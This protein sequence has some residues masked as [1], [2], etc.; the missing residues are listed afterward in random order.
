METTQRF[1]I[2]ESH[3]LKHSLEVFH[4]A[5]EIYNHQVVMYPYLEKQKDIIF[6]SAILHD[7]CDKKYMDQE[8]GIAM[9]KHHMKE[10][11]IEEDLV[12]VGKILS[13]MSYSTVKKNGYPEL[14]DYQLAYHIV[15]EA[16]LLAAYDLD[17]CL[18]YSLI[19]EKLDYLRALQR[20]VEITNER[21]LTYRKD[22]L[23][24][25]NYSKVLSS[26]LHRRAVKKVAL[27]EN[28]LGNF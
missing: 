10:V 14:G 12:V 22:K 28:I 23:F 6:T 24:L 13:T 7:M 1:K 5:N 3:A 18:I 8:N 16:D 2:D 4:Y 9:I 20:V 21:I 27:L 15:R 11:M 25:T 26:I 17:R 19:C